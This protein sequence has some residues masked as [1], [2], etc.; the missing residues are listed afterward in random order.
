MSQTARDLNNQSAA[1]L[2][3]INQNFCATISFKIQRNLIWKQLKDTLVCRSDSNLKYGCGFLVI[4][5]VIVQK[6]TVVSFSGHV[7]VCFISVSLY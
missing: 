5:F 1:D 7:F 3:K 6:A 2:Y 4:E